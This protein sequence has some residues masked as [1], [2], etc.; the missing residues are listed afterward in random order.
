MLIEVRI[1]ASAVLAAFYFFRRWRGDRFVRFF[2]FGIDPSATWHY[3]LVQLPLVLVRR[4]LRL[5][6][7]QTAFRSSI[8]PK[9]SDAC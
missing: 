4:S 9:A 7:D 8:R 6:L 3:C 2:N 5:G 1:F